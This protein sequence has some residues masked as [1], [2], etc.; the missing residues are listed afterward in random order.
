[1]S[2]EKVDRYKEQK[3]NRK[4]IIKK[5]KRKVAIEKTI[6]GIVCLAIVVWLGYSIYDLNIGSKTT[7]NEVD[8]TAISDYLN[9]LNAED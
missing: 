9:E 8:I 5:E 2:Q 6:A 1:M 7:T 3:K 4:D